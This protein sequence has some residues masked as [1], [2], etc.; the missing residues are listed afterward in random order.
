M[1]RLIERAEDYVRGAKELFEQGDKIAL[2]RA[3]VAMKRMRKRMPTQW[4]E[5]AIRT[6]AVAKLGFTSWEHLCEVLSG[7]TK[8]GDSFGQLWYNAECEAIVSSWFV[9][10]E[11]ALEHMEKKKSHFLLPYDKQFIVVQPSFIEGLYVDVADDNWKVVNR[12]LVEHYGNDAWESLCFDRMEHKY[13][14]F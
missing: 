7:D 8:S 9:N 12:N 5:D 1:N 2:S 13:F 6:A 10:Y 11:E 14:K 3:K 4:T